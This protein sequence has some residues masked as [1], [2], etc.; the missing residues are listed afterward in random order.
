MT[1]NKA[2]TKSITKIDPKEMDKTIVDISKAINDCHVRDQSTT[3]S[4]EF[5]RV[6]CSLM[7]KGQDANW[8]GESEAQSSSSNSDGHAAFSTAPLLQSP[9]LHAKQ[10]DDRGRPSQKLVDSLRGSLKE[11]LTVLRSG[12]DLQRQSL[13]F[14]LNSDRFVPLKRNPLRSEY[15]VNEKTVSSI[16]NTR[17]GKTLFISI[18]GRNPLTKSLHDS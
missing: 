16:P 11:Q 9:R 7:D 6:C 2:R 17:K 10:D 13:S 4:T 18:L 14:P 12:Q 15:K 3:G 8:Q 1:Y 5:E